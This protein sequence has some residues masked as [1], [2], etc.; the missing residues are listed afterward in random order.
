MSLATLFNLEK[1]DQ[2]IGDKYYEP[3]EVARMNDFV[4]RAAA[5]KGVH[6]WH[7][8]E[9]EDE[10]FLVIKGTIVMDTEHESVTLNEG[11]GY[12]IPKGVKH[13]PRAEERA[14][15]L[16]IEPAALVHTKK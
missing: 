9:H 6:H 4:I 16:L 10:C 13:C 15:V 8:H 1:I 2:Q 14:L 5:F 12:M 3:I 7:S 11:D